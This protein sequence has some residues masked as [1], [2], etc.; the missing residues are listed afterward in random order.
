MLAAAV[1]MLVFALTGRRITRGEGALMMIGY[2][3]Y[4]AL[5][6]RQN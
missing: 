4:I 2:A 5:L 6:A 1:V 3:A